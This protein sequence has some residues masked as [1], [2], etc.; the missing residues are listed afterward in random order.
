VLR[1][2]SDSAT[3]EADHDKE[4]VDIIEAVEE[5]ELPEGG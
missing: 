2:S 1:S 4:G 5:L 3:D